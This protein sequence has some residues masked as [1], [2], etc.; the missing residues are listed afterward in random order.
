MENELLK[1]K[2]TWKELR[3]WVEATFTSLALESGR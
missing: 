1:E 3:H 2:S